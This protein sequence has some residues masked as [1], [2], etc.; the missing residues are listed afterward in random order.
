MV[1]KEVVNKLIRLKIYT[2]RS[3]VYYQLLNSFLIILIFL[4]SYELSI[5]VKVGA[6]IFS[7]ITII[8][9]GY[10]DT[11]LKIL[12]REQEHFNQENKSTQKILER[13]EK[14]EGKL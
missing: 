4:N 12:E 1:V 2:Q 14:I 9:I 11:K 3:L 10:Y 8:T 13:L 5:L 6:I 7:I